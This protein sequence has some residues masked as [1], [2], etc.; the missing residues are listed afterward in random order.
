M[1]QAEGRVYAETLED[2]RNLDCWRNHR[3]ACV[4]TERPVWPSEQGREWC[5]GRLVE[6]Q[7][8]LDLTGQ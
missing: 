3:M 5:H 8:K 1:F 7:G 6:R 4:A 2:G